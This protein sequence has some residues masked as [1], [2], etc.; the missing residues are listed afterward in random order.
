MIRTIAPFD[1]IG[2]AKTYNFKDDLFLIEKPVVK[3][4]EYPIKLEVTVNIVCLKGRIKGRSNIRYF[5][6]EAPCLLVLMAEHTVAIDYI[7]DDFSADFI[8]MSKSFANGLNIEDRL[9]VFF[10]LH[11]KPFIPLSKLEL[12]SLGDYFKNI[13]KV[14]RQIDN[15][16]SIKIIQH[17]TKAY[18]YGF[19]YNIQ[20]I[21]QYKKEERK[22]RKGELVE[23]FLTAV[24]DNF[25]LEREIKFY[26]DKLSVTPK[27]LSK[28]IKHHNGLSAKQWIDDYVVLEA[29][30]LLKS[31]SKTIQQISDELNFPS[32][33]FFGKYFK[34][35]VG[36][37][38]LEY[39][40]S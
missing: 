15:P 16:Y 26:A 20:R 40:K 39:R 10:S 35:S 33:S 18:F 28:V 11:Q 3:H 30:A 12:T 31:T 14:L 32:Q 24:Q 4:L 38:P 8:I 6:T 29:K 17:F 21:E 13:K 37:S 1:F 9:P 5:D 2:I 23:K 7:S 25:K 19:S 34:R 36:L 22:P 27:Y